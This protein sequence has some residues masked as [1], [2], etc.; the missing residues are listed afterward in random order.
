MR[1]DIHKTEAFD[2]WLKNLRDRKAVLA[3][4]QRLN[5]AVLGNFGDTKAVGGGVFE[6]RIFFGPG[7]RLYY[8]ISNGTILLLLL[9]GDKSTQQNDIRKAKELAGSLGSTP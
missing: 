2:K 8:T 9:G 5:R 3:I 1:Y 6:M 4:T 7:Y